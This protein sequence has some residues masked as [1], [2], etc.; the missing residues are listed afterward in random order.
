MTVYIKHYIK[1]EAD[2]PK[3]DGL[4]I[5]QIKIKNFSTEEDDEGNELVVEHNYKL[6][7]GDYPFVLLNTSLKKL[8][9]ER[10]EWWLEERELLTDDEIDE[11]IDKYAFRVPYDGSNKFYDEIHYQAD[12]NWLKSKLR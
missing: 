2:L 3:K 5:V 12:I 9:V 7:Y 10:M 11:Q 1:S 6:V 4:Y 8:W